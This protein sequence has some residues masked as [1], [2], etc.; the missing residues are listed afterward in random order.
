[1]SDLATAV[2]ILE[3]VRENH[4]ELIPAD[5]KI[6]EAN[7]EEDTKRARDAVIELAD[8]NLIPVGYRCEHIGSGKKVKIRAVKE[9]QWTELDKIQSG[10]CCAWYAYAW[11]DDKGRIFTFALIN[12]KA[13]REQGWFEHKKVH[14]RWFWRQGKWDEVSFYIYRY[15][16]WLK[17][18]G[19]V[20]LDV[21]FPQKEDLP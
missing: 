19:F 8:G 20:I 7:F 10:D 12:I 1:M 17:D 9:G 13:M 16:H 3:W 15:L 4:P 11:H 5:A 14:D 6:R 18:D 2:K 21:T